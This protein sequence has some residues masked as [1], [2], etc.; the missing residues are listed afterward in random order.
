ES[1]IAVG[2]KK[3]N[4]THPAGVSGFQY[5][6]IDSK[7]LAAQANF[8]Y[9]TNSTDA[10]ANAKEVTR[11]ANDLTFATTEPDHPLVILQSY[12]APTAY[13]TDWDRAAMAIQRLGGTRQVFNALNQP[14]TA[15]SPDD[16]GRRGAYAFIGRVGGGAPRAEAS[17]PL[18]GRP[19]RLEGLL[20]RSRS[21]DF[22]PMM[23]SNAR[24]DGST[25]VN[26]D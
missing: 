17:Y 22:E 12:R 9:V 6:R 18:T 5:L 16:G 2:D 7:T 26:E 21:A 4:F 10:A 15:L 23:V 1:T 20:M 19:G 24:A 25:P 14:N 3:Y 13:S 8:G 11:L